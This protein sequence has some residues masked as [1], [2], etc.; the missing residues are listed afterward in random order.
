MTTG[1]DSTD[2]AP[3]VRQWFEELFTD[4]DL[5]V[6]DDILADDVKYHGPTSLSPTDVTGPGDIKEYVQ[7]YHASFPDLS[8]TI[9]AI[10]EMES[11]MVVEWTASGTQEVPLYEMDS[12]GETFTE[13]GINIFHIEN[14]AITEI[15]SEWD[16]LKMVQELEIVPQTGDQSI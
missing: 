15:K 9:D 14:G 8:Y 16:T 7:T 6:A 2:S 1:T 11:G 13:N 10:H 5:S 12:A 4:G 3:L